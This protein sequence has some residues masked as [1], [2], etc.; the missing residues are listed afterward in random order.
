MLPAEVGSQGKP[1]PVR[2]GL[3]EVDGEA[4][5]RRDGEG[6]DP[7]SA[8]A[9]TRTPDAVASVE[10]RMVSSNLADEGI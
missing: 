6:D 4:S 9:A 7:A 8:R 10:L 3:G 5:A 1:R 2:L